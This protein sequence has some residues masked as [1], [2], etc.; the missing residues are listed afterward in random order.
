MGSFFDSDLS[1][2]KKFI[3]LLLQCRLSNPLNWTFVLATI[4]LLLSHLTSLL[5]TS[6]NEVFFKLKQVIMT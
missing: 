4:L 5:V 3:M 6:F 2:S 1:N